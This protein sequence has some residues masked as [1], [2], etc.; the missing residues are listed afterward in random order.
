MLGEVMQSLKLKNN[1]NTL[2]P[3][4]PVI[5]Q[6]LLTVGRHLL[7]TRCLG[8]K[9]TVFSGSPTWVYLEMKSAWNEH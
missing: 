6:V 4:P 7:G 8:A 3:D 1:W 9:Y 2:L 5:W